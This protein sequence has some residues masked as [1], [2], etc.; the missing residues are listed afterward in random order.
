[1]E[2][3]GGDHDAPLERVASSR[4]AK[5]PR[6]VVFFE[7]D[8]GDVGRTAFANLA[9]ASDLEISLERFPQSGEEISPGRVLV[10][11]VDAKTMQRALDLLARL[12][13]EAP[14]ARVL[15]VGVQLA[16][17]QIF[18]L[19]TAGA[20]DF[21]SAPYSQAE[22]LTRT[23]RAVGRVESTPDRDIRSLLNARA[24]GLIGNAPAFVKQVARLPVFA[25]CDAGV[26]ILGE[27]GTG[28]ELFAQAIHYLSVRVSRP[29]VPVN[30]SAIPEE[31]IES[32]LFGHT[33]GAYT[34]AHAAREGLIAASEGGTLFLD[35]VASLPWSAQG[36]LLRFLQEREYRSV[37]SNTLM[38]AN[39]RVLAASNQDLATLVAKGQFRQDLYFRLNVLTL[40]LPPLRDRREDIPVLALHFIRRF[41]AD[42]ERPVKELTP[43][44]I[45][46]LLEYS[47]PGNVRELSHAMERTVLLGDGPYITPAD[48]EIGEERSPQQD[49]SFQAAKARV[50]EQFER[51]YIE[52]IL[53]ACD[54]NITHAAKAAK[55]NRRALWELI[56]KHRIE[57]KRFRSLQEKPRQANQ[58]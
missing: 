39:V 14:S 5:P 29:W 48:I 19:L 42:F 10:V 22:L 24:R 4:G 37:G 26:L 52:R 25:G 46:H 6:C 15:V 43:S 2:I 35:E 50:V 41:A 33:K 3:K 55:K 16:R 20:Y 40:T 27:T 53:T 58:Q 18:R 31:L 7:N 30:C 12:P 21:V 28:K 38:H 9:S 57:A 56:R 49:E 17:Q 45:R 13:A 44:A 51:S 8:D 1:V 36:K 47:W 32:E 54:G 23:L 34:T 11:P